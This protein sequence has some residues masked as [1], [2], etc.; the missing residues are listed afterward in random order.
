MSREQSR[1]LWSDMPRILW[2]KAEELARI[3][4]L[5]CV[6]IRYEGQV[7]TYTHLDGPSGC[8]TLF[9]VVQGGPQ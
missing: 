1:T 2:R 5:V 6:E 7:Y 3:L 4:G 8:V 9:G